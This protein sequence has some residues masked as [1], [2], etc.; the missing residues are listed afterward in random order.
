MRRT[1]AVATSIHAM[2]A[3]FIREKPNRL[4]KHCPTKHAGRAQNPRQ[5]FMRG[6][7]DANVYRE[8]CGRC[9]FPTTSMQWVRPPASRI[10]PGVTVCR[11][12]FRECPFLKSGAVI[13]G[14]K[15]CIFKEGKG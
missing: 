5:I 10:G 14:S 13:F 9:R 1:R 2:S 7:R 6:T 15:K 4:A 12:E 11:R 3:G 8:N